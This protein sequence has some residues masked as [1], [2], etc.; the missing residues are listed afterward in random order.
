MDPLIIPSA[1]SVT[2]I[3]GQITNSYDFKTKT[4]VGSVKIT[5]QNKINKVIKYLRQI[6]TGMSSATTTYPTP[7]HTIIVTDTENSNLVIFLGVN[8]IGGRNNVVGEASANRLTGLSDTKRKELLELIGI[9]DYR[10]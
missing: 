3:E 10:Y 8:W 1:D 7:T 2:M 5:D 9:D 6:N 4:Y